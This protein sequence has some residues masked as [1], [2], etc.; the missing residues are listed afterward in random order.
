MVRRLSKHCEVS[1][2]H[3]G[4]T[5]EISDRKVVL[6]AQVRGVSEQEA[7]WYLERRNEFKEREEVNALAEDPSTLRLAT[8]YS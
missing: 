4:K 8:L 2:R 6:L 3:I 5:M 7:R 1:W